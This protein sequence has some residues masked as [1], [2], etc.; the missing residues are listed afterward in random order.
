MLLLYVKRSRE[1]EAGVCPVTRGALQLKFWREPI[2]AAEKIQNVQDIFLNTVRKK[3]VP[4]TIFLVN[5][6]KLQGNISGFDNFS[7]LLKRESQIQLIY[8]HAISTIMPSG[9]LD[10]FQEHDE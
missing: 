7:I 8:K 1:N 3:H 10:L 5:G 4:V 9:E 2:V 6:V